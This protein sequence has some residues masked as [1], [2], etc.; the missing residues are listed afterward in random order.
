MTLEAL[1]AIIAGALVSGSLYALM[2]SGLSLVW[3]TVRMFNFAHGALVMVGAYSAWYVSNR[4][5]IAKALQP[6]GKSIVASGEEAGALGSLLLP[7]GEWILSIKGGF[8]LALGVPFAI[9]CCG[10]VGYI[11]YVLLVKPFVGKPGADLIVIITTI[12]GASFMQNGVQVIFGP[13]YK[14]LDRIL[15]G[16]PLQILET[17]IGLQEVLIIVL[18]PLTLFLLHL[19][20]K[21]SKLGLAIRAVAQNDDFAHLVGINVSQIYPLTFVVSSILAGLCGVMLGGLFFILPTMGAQELLFAFVVV[22]FGGLG[23][24]PGT[25]VGA[26]V[27]GFIRESSAYIIDLYWAPVVLFATLIIVLIFRPRGLMGGEDS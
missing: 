7:L 11:M 17:A 9:L 18:T 5:G 16:P 24:L 26:Y 2:A 4:G 13:R 19:F 1:V 10:L 27:I 15:K 20:L 23:S 14:Q 12:A 25:I 21:H 8:G 6:I 3:G 22:V